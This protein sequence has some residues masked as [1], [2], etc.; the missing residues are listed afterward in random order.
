MKITPKNYTEGT[1]FT[2]D[3]NKGVVYSKADVKTEIGNRFLAEIGV[4]NVKDNYYPGTSA[5]IT[6][7]DVEFADAA[8]EVTITKMI[9]TD[10]T[11]DKE[12]NATDLTTFKPTITVNEFKDG[13]AY[14][15]I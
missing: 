2:I 7:K 15:T 3:D 12:V 10:G 1:F 9:L 11:T 6:V 8:G 13:Y 5:T 4:T 14:Y